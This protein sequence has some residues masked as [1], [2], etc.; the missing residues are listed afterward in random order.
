[1]EIELIDKVLA[2]Q[3]AAFLMLAVYTRSLYKD[4]EQE[5]KERRE[6]WKAFSDLLESVNS[7]MLRTAEALQELKDAIQKKN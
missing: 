6:A 3:G 2:T 5:R 1:M 4:R 7:T